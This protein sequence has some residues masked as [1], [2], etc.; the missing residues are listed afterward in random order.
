MA[1]ALECPPSERKNEESIIAFDVNDH[2]LSERRRRLVSGY[3]GSSL[4]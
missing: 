3:D 4:A 2:S 1:V